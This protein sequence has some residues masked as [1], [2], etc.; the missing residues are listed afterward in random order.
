MYLNNLIFSIAKVTSTIQQIWRLQFELP[1]NAC[2]LLVWLVVCSTTDTTPSAVFDL[3]VTQ[4]MS[5]LSNLDGKY[6]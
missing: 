4:H 6:N 1:I 3:S 2:L 5:D